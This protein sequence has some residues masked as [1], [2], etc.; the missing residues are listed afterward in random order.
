MGE[1]ENH[2]LLGYL[3]SLVGRG[4]I[5]RVEVNFM[6]VGPH[7]HEIRPE[8]SRVSP[9]EPVGLAEGMRVV[10]DTLESLRCEHR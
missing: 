5:S 7:P 3:D 4:V 6:T 8:F 10:M 2:I 1:N 9:A